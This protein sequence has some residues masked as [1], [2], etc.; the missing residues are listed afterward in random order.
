MKIE[1]KVNLALIIIFIFGI[2]INGVLLSNVLEQKTQK[3]IHSKAMTLMALNNSIGEYTNKRLQ[4]LLIK[5]MEENPNI[6]IPE[7]ISSFSVREIFGTFRSNPGYADY[8][9]KDATLNPT[10]LRDKADDFETEIINR[11]RLSESNKT[12]LSG[13]RTIL[14][15]KL[16]YTAKPF[17]I[18]NKSCLRCHTTPEK[19]PKSQLAIYGTENGFGWKLNEILGIQIIY[20]PAEQIIEYAHR[21]FVIIIGIITMIFAAMVITVNLFLK[22]AILK[23]IKKIAR[24]VNQVSIGNLHVNLDKQKTDEIGNVAE[25]F[26]RMKSS[27]EIAMGMLSN[28]KP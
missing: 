1:T 8:F 19:A 11:F 7:A 26:Y 28:K 5:K 9:Y 15:T 4:P 13:Y 6:F 12:S 22:R 16:Y 21:L 17:S 10:N 27:L 2:L 23:R 25:S 3:E 20:I 18:N 24:V 14:G